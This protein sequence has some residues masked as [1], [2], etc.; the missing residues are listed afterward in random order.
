MAMVSFLAQM[1]RLVTEDKDEIDN[2]KEGGHKADAYVVI[3]RS[4]VEVFGYDA[5]LDHDHFLKRGMRLYQV[6]ANSLKA[7]Y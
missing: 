4:F 3:L 5:M 1:E 2:S 7:Y 6:I